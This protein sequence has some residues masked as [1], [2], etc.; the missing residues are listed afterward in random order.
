MRKLFSSLFI[1]LLAFFFLFVGQVSAKVLTSES[2]SISVEKGEIINDDLFI[3]AQSVDIEGTVNG[4][5]FIGAQTVKVGGVINGSLHV[6]ANNIDLS[7]KVS[8]NVYAGSQSMVVSGNIGGSILAGAATLSVDK[9]AQVGGSIIA[10]AGILSIDSTVKRNVVAG[11]GNLTLGP[12]TKIGKDLYY[13]NGKDQKEANMAEGATVSGMI[14]KSEFGGTSQKD[15]QALQKEVPSFIKGV[16]WFAL[17]TSFVG[18]LIIGLIYTKL[19]K[20]HSAD[21]VGLLNKSFWKSLGVGLLTIAALVPALLIMAITIIGLP[22]AGLVIVV[23]IL[24]SCLAKIVVGICFGGWL[25]NKFNWKG[26]SPFAA[27]ALGLAGI[28]IL[29]ALPVVG[30]F[31]SFGAFL[32]GLGALTLQLFSKKV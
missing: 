3:G 17:I 13:A 6:G 7:G 20:K 4:D 2:G 24:F 5:V 25:K 31:V 1:F 32:S 26:L 9:S 12:N 11:T 22:L 15:I 28:Y 10:G 29:Q 18:A 21:V 27:F 30:G 8:G 14:H 23:F 16:R 19:F